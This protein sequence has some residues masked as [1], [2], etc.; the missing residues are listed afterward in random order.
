M[1]L[2][3]FD[4]DNTL[5]K[6][7]SDF[8]W[9]QFICKHGLVDREAFE[10]KNRDFHLQYQAGTLDP[11][12]F[13]EFALKP[14]TRYSPGELARWH[15][16]YMKDVIMGCIEDSARALVEQ[17]REMGHT[18][19]VITATNEFV[20]APIVAEFGIEHLI[21]PRVELVDGRYTGKSPGSPCLGE[22]KVIRFNEWL[23]E[24]GNSVEESWFYSDSRNDIPLLEVVEHPIAANPDDT[25]RAHAKSK[26]WPI[27]ELFAQTQ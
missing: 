2:A 19:L 22:G 6:G 14:L 18:L 13:L 23:A 10:S 26:G 12:E 8:M 15:K 21:A 27:M 17:H 9:G 11:A 24:T 4:L 16:R 7:D 5:L 25:L 3:I 20:T 1:K